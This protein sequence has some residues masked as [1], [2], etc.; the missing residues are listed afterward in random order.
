MDK[1][2]LS[3]PFFEQT[4][5]E[6]NWY[7]QDLNRETEKHKSLALPSEESR[8]ELL[9]ER[10]RV[11]QW[12]ILNEA[13]AI[14]NS[15]LHSESLPLKFIKCAKKLV[16]A[17]EALL[18]LKEEKDSSLTIIKHYSTTEGLGEKL[19]EEKSQNPQGAI[20]IIMEN[21]EVINRNSSHFPSHELYGFSA[22]K[23]NLLGIPIYASGKVIGALL[24]ANKWEED[25]FTR[26]DQEL[27]LILGAQL[28]IALENSRLY[29]KTDEKL[30]AKVEELEQVNELLTKKH[31][32]LAKSLEIHKQL[33]DLA[34]RGEGIEAICNILASII[35][36]PVQVEDYAFNIKAT[37]MEHLTGE[38]LSGRKLADGCGY[39]RH[40]KELFQERK[41]VEITLD[42]NTIQYMV[43]IIAGQQVLGIITTVYADR[44]LGQL[45]RVAMEQG[46]TIIALEM[47]KEKA[48]MEQTRR[49]Q[50]H[51][52]EQVLERDYES[53]EW[54]HHRALQL[55]FN[56]KHA[57]QVMTVEIEPGQKDRSRPEL[58]Q[59][60]RELY[61]D[62][63][64]NVVVIIKH[65]RA[66][67]MFSFDP[68]EEKDGVKHL[69]EMLKKWLERSVQDGT[70]WVALGTVCRRLE[71]C[72]LSYRKAVTTLDI[73]KAL[74]LTQKVVSNDNLGIFSLIEIN[75][76][77][78]AEFT[79]RTLGALLDYD[80][81]HKTQLVSTLNLYYRHNSN[82]LKA[83]REGYLN[84]S[85][86]KYRLRRIQEITGLDLKD[87]DVGLQLQF[88]LKLMEFVWSDS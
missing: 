46:A 81:K 60:I 70:W 72:F 63:T 2:N 3:F 44:S 18:A 34:L 24:M 86:M 80:Q 5:S 45:D 84:P 30:Q 64:T 27:L 4:T 73:M 55:G 36:A 52:L 76:Q 19:I 42:S 48:A 79:Q 1:N 71:D 16:S 56:L 35:G 47:L 74:R 29:E 6:D 82:V 39:E 49:L 65:N 87:A 8:R 21:E 17:G 38:F 13:T 20:K 57:C 83:S 78:F 23:K 50:E 88:A 51:F 54:V 59:E 40:S 28:G 31:K 75:T 61:I 58:Y 15:Q 43:P 41:A 32:V 62:S 7:G 9:K 14:L 67:I 85:T 22:I 37:T 69:A 12:R 33:T 53:E 26:D 25:S 66:I 11:I 10:K 68:P 77:N